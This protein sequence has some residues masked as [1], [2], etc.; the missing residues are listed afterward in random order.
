MIDEAYHWKP[1][2]APVTGLEFK[3]NNWALHESE[4]KSNDEGPSVES[5]EDSDA[6]LI[7]LAF[8]SEDI[9]LKFFSLH[10]A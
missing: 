7:P 8:Y 5:I 1:Y 10:F 4:H 3:W 2:L 6:L 9:D